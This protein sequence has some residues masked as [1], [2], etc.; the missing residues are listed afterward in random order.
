M[1]PSWESRQSRTSP[2]IF[3]NKRV[4]PLTRAVSPAIAGSRGSKMNARSLRAPSP[5]TSLPIRGVNGA[6][7]EARTIAETSNHG[8][9]IAV[10]VPTSECRRSKLLVAHSYEFGLPAV[11]FDANPPPDPWSRERCQVY[12]RFIK[13]PG[14]VTALTPTVT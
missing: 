7:D 13:I 6:P 4:I 2:G 5:F 11:R 8:L 9:G 12:E 10:S 3:A 14:G 1:W